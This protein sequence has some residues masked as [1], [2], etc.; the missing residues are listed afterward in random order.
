MR[1]SL[2]LHLSLFRRQKAQISRAVEGHSAAFRAYE[3]RYRRQTRS[4]EQVLS[5]AEIGSYLSLQL[6]TVTRALSH[7]Q[8]LGLIT[9]DRR[10]ITIN[11]RPA[12]QSRL[13][14]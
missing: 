3:A 12:L 10:R 5:R 6:E 8:A 2:S 1:A 14:A 11:D 4:Y 9:V 13:A 7:L